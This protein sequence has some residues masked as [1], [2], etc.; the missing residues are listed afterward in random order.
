MYE[1]ASQSAMGPIFI[2]KLKK[3]LHERFMGH[4]IVKKFHE[5]SY[6]RRKWE[7]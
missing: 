5:V 1:L 6:G 2:W 4:L 3:V 7:K